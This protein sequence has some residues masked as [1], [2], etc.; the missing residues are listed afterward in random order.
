MG[1]LLEKSAERAATG[2]GEE[3]EDDDYE[4]MNPHA[5]LPEDWAEVKRTILGGG[6]GGGGAGNYS[7]PRP[8]TT[9]TGADLSSVAYSSLKLPSSSA[10][11]GGQPV[12]TN[13]N[14]G[15][16]EMR[17]RADLAAGGGRK[18]SPHTKRTLGSSKSGEGFETGH[19]FQSSL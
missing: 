13:S 8:Q 1:A 5:L 15:T 14:T 6:G 18:P 17:L 4:H 11:T 10:T 2:V 7:V 9:K 16:P 3:D 12:T 19:C